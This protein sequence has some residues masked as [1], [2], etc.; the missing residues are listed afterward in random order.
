[1]KNALLGL[2][3][4]ALVLAASL[5][6]DRSLGRLDGRRR[7]LIFEPSTQV[8]HETPEYRFTARIN[9]LGFRD[10][11]F[12]IVPDRARRALALGDS[13]TFGVGVELEDAWPKLLEAGLVEDGHD[14]EL[15]N[16]GRPGVPPAGY[17]EIAQRAIPLLRP[18]LVIVAVVQGDDL[19]QILLE[20][21]GAPPRATQ[22]GSAAVL[23]LLGS[24]YP[25]LVRLRQRMRPA[26]PLEMA[27]EWR[28]LAATF[29]SELEP[30]HRERYERM[31]ARMREMLLAGG[32]N[33]GLVSLAIKHPD[34]FAWTLRLEDADVRGALHELSA[35]LAGVRE[36]VAAFA[37]S[38][39]VV[40]LPSAAYVSPTNWESYRRMGFTMTADFLTTGRMDEAIDGAA[41]E[42]GLPFVSCTETFRSAAKEE[43]LFFP[44]DG[45][46]TREGNRRLADC[47]SPALAPY[48]E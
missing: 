10:R 15:A 6:V 25:N 38:A 20:R 42:A 24:L 16:L 14:I 36:L 46:L 13:F 31:P 23:R 35:M 7:G 3:S 12:G 30:V 21:L 48:L 29:V 33:P 45:H 18:G 40:S 28:R 41:R 4:F 37:A 32:L 19:G 27:T 43:E 44:I 26:T 47:L 22:P 34:H 1:L 11:E 8:L 9:S 39:L 17:L 2:A 5:L